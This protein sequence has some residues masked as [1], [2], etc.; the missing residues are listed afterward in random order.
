MLDQIV[1][2]AIYFRDL[3]PTLDDWFPWLRIFGF[4]LL[5]WTDSSCR[6]KQ[7]QEWANELEEKDD[8]S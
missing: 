5:L 6:G 8:E 3:T 2:T 4:A 1:S 7:L